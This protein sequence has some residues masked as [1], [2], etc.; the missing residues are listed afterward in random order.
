MYGLRQRERGARPRVRRLSASLY[1]RR[2][3]TAGVVWFGEELPRQSLLQSQKA[4]GECELFMSLGTSSVVYPA[5]GLIDLALRNGAR[6][7][8]VNPQQ[9]P[10][11]DTADWSIRGKCG[12]VL[13]QLMQ[14]ALG[15]S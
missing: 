1:L 9:T 10:H 4:A 8:E 3:A 2:Q 12:E 6:V 7:L 11:S 14:A 15:A 13:P 5:A